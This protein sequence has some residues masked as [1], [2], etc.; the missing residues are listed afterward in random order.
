MKLA[1]DSVPPVILFLFLGAKDSSSFLGIDKAPEIKHVWLHL[2][3]GIDQ[4]RKSDKGRN[5]RDCICLHLISVIRPS[6]FVLLS[7]YCRPVVR[8]CNFV[9]VSN[10]HKVVWRV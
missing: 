8:F 6:I 3:K 7:C 4:E 10:F 9:N 2:L 5:S 1:T